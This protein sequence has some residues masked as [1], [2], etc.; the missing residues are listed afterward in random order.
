MNS[1]RASPNR[2][3][4]DRRC[5]GSVCAWREPRSA[6]L[7]S[8]KLPE[9]QARKK[10][11]VTT[12]TR[13]AHDAAVALPFANRPVSPARLI[14]L[15][16]RLRCRVRRARKA[17]ATVETAFAAQQGGQI[18]IAHLNIERKSMNYKFDDR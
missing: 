7:A 2:S 16:R 12:R 6:S 10:H 17:A 14:T 5:G 11:A 9:R 3:H 1:Q 13:A 15:A 18:P 4:A 8:A